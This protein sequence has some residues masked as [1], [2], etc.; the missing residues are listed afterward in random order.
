MKSCEGEIT[1]SECKD[2][3]RTVPEEKPK[4]M[5]IWLVMEA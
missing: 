5:Q 4:G 3:D 1:Q 2:G